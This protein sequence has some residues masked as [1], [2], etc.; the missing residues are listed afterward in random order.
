MIKPINMID[1]RSRIFQMSKYPHYSTNDMSTAYERHNILRTKREWGW[2]N[3]SWYDF[4]L[5]WQRVNNKKMPPTIIY[6]LDFVAFDKTISIHQG[7]IIV[8]RPWPNIMADGN[9]KYL[10]SYSLYKSSLILLLSW[11]L[12]SDHNPSK[13]LDFGF[14]DYC[15]KRTFIFYVIELGINLP[16]HHKYMHVICVVHI[17]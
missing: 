12:G 17:K 6:H 8:F 11:P 4:G 2:I 3:F 1:W 13:C 14:M 7:W 10:N 15:V 16:L 5:E 9:S